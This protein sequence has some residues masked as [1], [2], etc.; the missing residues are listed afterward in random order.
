MVGVDDDGIVRGLHLNHRQ[1][2]QV[3]LLV[4]SIMKAFHPPLLPHNYSLLF[5]PVVRPGP[6]GRDLKVMCLNFEA[7]PAL[8]QPGLYQTDQ[9]E[10]FLRRDGGVE[11]PLSANVIQEW[12]RQ[13][14]SGEIERLHHY[15]ETLLSE[16]RLLLQ[17]ICRQNQTIAALHSHITSRQMQD[18]PTASRSLMDKLKKKLQ[19]EGQKSRSSQNS[20]CPVSTDPLLPLEPSG[21][22]LDII[23]DHCTGGTN[24]PLGYS[25]PQRNSQD[26]EF[27]QSQHTEQGQADIPDVIAVRCKWLGI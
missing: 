5:L 9:G 7:L 4:D 8:T 24:L 26:P 22:F 11:G 14:W 17:E 13:R 20:L 27:L 19:R 1:E 10:M 2:D 15:V 16:Q 23:P 25:Q 6:E 3:R 12:A 18:R 21:T